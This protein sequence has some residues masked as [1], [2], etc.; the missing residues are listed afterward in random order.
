M[1]RHKNA[2][3]TPYGRALM[4]RRVRELGWSAAP[5]AEAAGVSVRTVRK[6]LARHRAEGAAGLLDRSSRPRSSLPRIAAG[7]QILIVRLRQCRM[8]A[9]EIASRLHLARSTV[10]AELAR[11]GLNRL[12]AL[13]PKEP[14]R[15]YERAR[16]GDLVHL[17]VKK[18]ARFD[19]PGH[20][21]TRSRRGQN[22][23]V[24]WEFV[25]VCIDDH[26]RLAYVEV[27]DDEAG[28][29]CARFLARA[30]V[31]FAGHGICV[32]RVMTDNGTGYRSHLFRQARE[33]LGLR[34]LRTRPYTPKTN[35]KAERFIKT[36][37]ED[38]AYAVPYRSSLNRRRQL[39]LWLRH[40]NHERPH[41]SLAGLPPASRLPAQVN[42]L[43]GLHN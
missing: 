16:P 25:H 10:A 33:A 14:V 3:T 29:S 2:R 12:S 41:G 22:D 9:E 17:D 26:A 40:Y 19:K 34:H 24:G 28:D 18:L 13:A 38:W 31:W 43:A 1:N 11:L 20:R 21:V 37:L 27:L 15:R 32:R 30:V 23:G 42:N 6:W 36:M 8:T 39:P 4:V 35:G 5:A 7:W